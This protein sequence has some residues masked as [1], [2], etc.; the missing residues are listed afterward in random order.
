MKVAALGAGVRPLP[1]YTGSWAALT[2]CASSAGAALAV[3][4]A[5]ALD[6]A[7]DRA[8]A[9]SEVITSSPAQMRT[10][11]IDMPLHQGAAPKPPMRLLRVVQSRF[12]APGAAPPK[13]SS[14]IAIVSSW[15][16]RRG[17]A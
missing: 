5:L 8:F 7:L 17:S 3:A 16:G 4:L 1:D 6:L 15:S 9:A 14:S 11:A 13:T 12:P 2:A 10:A